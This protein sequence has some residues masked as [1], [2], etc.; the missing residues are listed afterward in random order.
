[1]EKTYIRLK[2]IKFEDIIYNINKPITEDQLL[3]IVLPL[4]SS[5]L[6]KE[7]YQNIKI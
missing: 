5:K 4:K 1:M 7:K 6:E 2:P 3:F